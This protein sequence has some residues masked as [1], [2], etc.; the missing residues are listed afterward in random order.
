MASSLRLRTSVSD[1][2]VVGKLELRTRVTK[3][4][5]PTMGLGARALGCGPSLGLWDRNRGLQ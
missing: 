2:A 1:A 4:K 3:G 5:G